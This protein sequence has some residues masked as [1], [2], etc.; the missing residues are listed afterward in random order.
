MWI[1]C[2]L[3]TLK[4]LFIYNFWS[5]CI[6]FG[7]F[8]SKCGQY[9][10]ILIIL[11]YHWTI[12]QWCPRNLLLTRGLL[13][14]EGHIF[15]LT[16]Y[17]RYWW[18][19]HYHLLYCLQILFAFLSAKTTECRK[20]KKQDFWDHSAILSISDQFWWISIIFVSFLFVFSL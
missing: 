5:F 8:W 13:G 11:S 18:Y 20:F 1:L 19:S 7:H 3:L 10:T 14:F 17:W 15:F 9:W 12:L 16:R 4:K 2:L 6:N